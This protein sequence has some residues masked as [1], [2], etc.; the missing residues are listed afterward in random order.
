MM[1]IRHDFKS[2]AEKFSKKMQRALKREEN[3]RSDGGRWLR[4]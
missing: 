2:F 3:F 4:N 1:E